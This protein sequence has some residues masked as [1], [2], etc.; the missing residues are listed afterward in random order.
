[1]DQ[2]KELVARNRQVFKLGAECGLCLMPGTWVEQDLNRSLIMAGLVAGG[3]DRKVEESLGVVVFKY[4]E[5][6]VAV[7]ALGEGA[8]MVVPRWQLALQASIDERCSQTSMGGED[9]GV[10]YSPAQS[11]E[12]GGPAFPQLDYVSR[13]IGCYFKQID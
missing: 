8:L 1:M 4:E 12:K 11:P 9:G 2:S 7:H 10:L 13:G 6:C 3:M 5:E